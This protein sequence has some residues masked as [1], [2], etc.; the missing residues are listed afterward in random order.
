[1]AEAADTETM[2]HG[3]AVPARRDFLKILTIASGA[4]GAGALVWPFIDA[5]N[6]DADEDAVARP[7]VNVG[8]IAENTAI[9]VSWNG[10]PIFI[11]KLTAQQIA[12]NQFIVPDTLPDPASYADR[13][14]P[15]YETF[16]VVVGLN[17]GVPCEVIGN[18]PADARG[19][20]DGWQCPCDGSVY[21]PLGR[22]RGGP[23]PRNLMIPRFTFLDDSQ[24]QFG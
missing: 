11:R 13:V 16:V 15:G 5:L 1:M 12:D 19:P 24:I 23:A 3:V 7:I 17:T 4:I 21:D 14:K 9:S 2:G 18:D 8:G 10:Q 20:F 6:P 22:V